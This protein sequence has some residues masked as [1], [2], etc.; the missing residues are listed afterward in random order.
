MK[1]PPT[2]EYFSSSCYLSKQ[3]TGIFWKI[4]I[5]EVRNR[6]DF[7]LVKLL[8]GQKIFE[9]DSKKIRTNLF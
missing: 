3:L 7:V 1:H 4:I 9:I 6:P 8:K 5:I 2:Q